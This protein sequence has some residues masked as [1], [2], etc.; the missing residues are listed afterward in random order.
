MQLVE[1]GTP[2]QEINQQTGGGVP[3][4]PMRIGVGYIELPTEL[5]SHVTTLA[6]G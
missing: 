6:S 4:Y 3:T 2:G 1:P 5:R